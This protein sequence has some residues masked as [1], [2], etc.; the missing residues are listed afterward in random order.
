MENPR[1]A[2]IGTG[3]M[4]AGM[5]ERLIDRGFAVDVWDRT[6]ATATRIAER[7]GVA[8]KQPTDAV[9][10]AGVVISMLPTASV[11][12]AVMLEQK[13]LNAMRP[14][15]IWAQMGTIGLDGT[16]RLITEAFNRRPD[17][18]FVDA[19]VSG[20]RGPARNGQ[21]IILASGPDRARAVV[22]AVF[23]ALAQ[24]VMWLGR[25]GM[26]MRMK[27]I[28]NTWLAFE[29]EAAAE[30]RESAERLGVSYEALVDT[31]RGG[32]MASPL[33]LARLDKMQKGDDSIDF[34]LEWALKDLDLTRQATGTG[35]IPVAHAIA[36]RWR[37]LVA[38]GLGRRDVTAAR[39]GFT[40][41][42]AQAAR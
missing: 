18:D 36:E 38:G 42:L 2:I 21:L 3:I 11:L 12:E 33:A 34:P 25:A 15:S 6:A 28:L 16:D 8:H 10:A 9:A 41:D 19:P 7:G 29:I 37:G 23:E 14:N 32:P 27:L 5:A 40:R 24:K 22:Q 20:T 35:A 17:V 13:V 31:V 26:G 4:G 30:I 39:L 1:V